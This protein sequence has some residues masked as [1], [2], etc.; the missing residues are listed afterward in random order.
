MEGWNVKTTKHEDDEILHT[1]TKSWKNEQH[2]SDNMEWEN[3]VAKYKLF[4]RQQNTISIGVL[5]MA[6]NAILTQGSCHSNHAR[7]RDEIIITWS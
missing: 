4:W 1:F 2:K 5:C 3:Q 7:V 6:L